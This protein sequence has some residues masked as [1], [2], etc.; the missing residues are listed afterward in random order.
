MCCESNIPSPSPHCR[1]RS[2]SLQCD[3]PTPPPT[4]EDQSR[5]QAERHPRETAASPEVHRM[6]NQI[7]EEPGSEEVDSRSG[8]PIRGRPSG[9]SEPF[10]GRLAQGTPLPANSA[11]R[12]PDTVCRDPV[13]D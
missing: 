5:L 4:P 1:M 3:M 6:P 8:W 7:T 12:I 2:S 10:P 13:T 9:T 11:P